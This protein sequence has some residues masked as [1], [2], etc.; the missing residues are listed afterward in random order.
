MEKSEYEHQEA[1]DGL[2]K[3]SISSEENDSIFSEEQ[4]RKIV[5]RID[6]RLVTVVGVCHEK[7][8]VLVVNP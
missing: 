4:Y 5:H 3:S 7:L 2:P 1:A 6:K 8:S